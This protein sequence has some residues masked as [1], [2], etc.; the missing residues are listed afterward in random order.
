MWTSG[1]KAT[2]HHPCDPVFSQQRGFQKRGEARPE[3]VEQCEPQGCCI[4]T[5][6][7]ATRRG[8]ARASRKCGSA[9]N[10]QGNVVWTCAQAVLREEATTPPQPSTRGKGACVFHLLMRSSVSLLC[11][12][13]RI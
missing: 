12:K 2:K 10:A 1:H 13:K 6:E 11:H 4:V 8:R 5:E 3:W 9:G 7:S